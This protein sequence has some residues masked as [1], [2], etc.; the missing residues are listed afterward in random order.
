MDALS[1][2]TTSSPVN[3]SPVRKSAR[4]YNPVTRSVPLNPGS[5]VGPYEILSAL[6]AGDMGD[7][8]KARDR[9]LDRIVA[10]KTTQGTAHRP[11]RAGSARDCRVD[12]PNVC[13]L[14][15]IGP[16]YS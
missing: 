6:G 13:T 1:C 8:W 16:D 9:R 7:V 12:P 5:V 11:V 10:I 3:A 4:S 15:D 2:I 14:Y